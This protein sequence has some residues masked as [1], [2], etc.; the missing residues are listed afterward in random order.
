MDVH[1]PKNGMYRYWS[2]PTLQFMATS[3]NQNKIP[4]ICR[5]YWDLLRMVTVPNT[6]DFP[7]LCVIPRVPEVQPFFWKHHRFPHF[8]HLGKFLGLY[9]KLTN[10]A[11]ISIDGGYHGYNLPTFIASLL[12]Y[13]QVKTLASYSDIPLYPLQFMWSPGGCTC[14]GI[15]RAAKGIQ[16][17]APG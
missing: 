16:G 6:C 17:E 1:P 4:G 12:I 2:I 14:T 15:L 7:Y 9:S 3:I 13:C 5:G 10:R 11:C 8:S